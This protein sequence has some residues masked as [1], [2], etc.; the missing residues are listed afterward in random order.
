M[1]Q[2]PA[3]PASQS[4]ANLVANTEKRLACGTIA[5]YSAPRMPFSAI[6]LLIRPARITVYRDAL[7]MTIAAQAMIV[8]LCKSADFLLGFM[9]GKLS[10]ATRTRWGRRKPF[11]ALCSPVFMICTLLLGSPGWFF[12][13]PHSA[14]G[15]STVTTVSEAC[16]A[17]V[18][19]SN[20]SSCVE[21]KACIDAAVA[22]STLRPWNATDGNADGVAAAAPA[23]LS[24]Y[25]G[26]L[27]FLWRPTA[28]SLEPPRQ[29]SLHLLGTFPVGT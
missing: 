5:A 6:D 16:A 29:P 8:S 3:S 19:S 26:V 9:L 11:I 17:L 14:D 28:G 20:R 25:F 18:D 27:Y 22:S 2:S 24:A 7:G 1:M 21:L 15:N 13:R 10:D 12:S 4:S 23:S